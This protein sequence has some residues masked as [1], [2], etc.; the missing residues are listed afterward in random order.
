MSKSFNSSEE[1]SD[2]GK[3]WHVV[4]NKRVAMLESCDYGDLDMLKKKNHKSKKKKDKETT[5]TSPKQPH[6]VKNNNSTIQKQKKSPKNN[7]S[8]SDGDG[9][10]EGDSRV[11]IPSTSPRQKLGRGALL[12]QL[13]VPSPDSSLFASGSQTG[14]S[15]SLLGS[16]KTEIKN[17]KRN[18]KHRSICNN[19]ILESDSDEDEGCEGDDGDSTFCP[20]T[21]TVPARRTTPGRKAKSRNRAILDEDQYYA[22]LSSPSAG[23]HSSSSSDDNENASDGVGVDMSKTSLQER[24]R[25]VVMSKQ[26]RKIDCAVCWTVGTVL[27]C[28]MRIHG[29]MLMYVTYCISAYS[30]K[31]PQSHTDVCDVLY[32]SLLFED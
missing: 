19:V 1:D 4:K 24:R 7:D 28:S 27:K 10:G 21:Q 8:Y 22:F 14:N 31:D 6:A 11:N 3:P 9:D 29:A 2:V 15:D 16:N 23:A 13:A 12:S 5:T 18:N 17:N 26:V 32:I 20:P 25:G 30:L